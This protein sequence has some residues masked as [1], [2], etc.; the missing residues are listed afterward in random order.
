MSVRVRP[1]L[2]AAV[3]A[4]ALTATACGP[5]AHD[6]SARPAGAGPVSGSP[7]TAAAQSASSRPTSAATGSGHL[8][9]AT[10]M[11]AV[12]AAAKKYQTAR[13]AMRMSV[14]QSAFTEHGDLSYATKTP[15]LRVTMTTP[16]DHKPLHEVV[17]EGKL[18]MAI[19]GETP[20]GKFVVLDLRKHGGRLGPAGNLLQSDPLA[21]ITATRAGVEKVSYAGERKLHGVSTHEYLVQVDPKAAL[22]ALGAKGRQLKQVLAALP[23]KHLTYKLWLDGENRMRQ[24]TYDLPGL[25]S[26]RIAMWHWGETLR[27]TAPPKSRTVPF[28][29]LVS[30]GMRSG[31]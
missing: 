23:A 20:T 14:L 18:Y 30:R 28:R 29:Q 10:L 7:S 8:T 21:S 11:P 2:P 4:L 17:V 25:G 9:K 1:L 22:K 16:L 27:I 24:V 6:S 31:L 12:A 5:A 15:S 13:F 19:P 3:A 26:A